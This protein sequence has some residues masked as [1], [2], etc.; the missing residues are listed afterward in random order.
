MDIRTARKQVLAAM[1]A[2]VSVLVLGDPGIGKTDMSTNLARDWYKHIEKTMG[3]NA[4]IGVST[5]FMATQSPLGF[6]GTPWKAEKSWT[7]PDGTVITRTITDPA[8]P[9]WYHYCK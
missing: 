8:L 6:T 4:R 5:F 3:P 1:I 2:G 7:K 9:M